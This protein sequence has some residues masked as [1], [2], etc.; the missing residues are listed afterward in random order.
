M[1]G[2]FM[3]QI[4]LLRR[5]T[6]SMIIIPH[7]VSIILCPCGWAELSPESN[8][9]DWNYKWTLIVALVG[10]LY[11][12]ISDARSHNYYH[13]IVRI[14]TLPHTLLIT[15]YPNNLLTNRFKIFEYQKYSR[16]ICDLI[17]CSDT[18]FSCFRSFYKQ[19]LKCFPTFQVTITCYSCSPSDLILL[20]TKF[21][22]CIHVN[23]PLHRVAI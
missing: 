23:L 4:Y 11:F 20:V 1:W 17:T 18:G 12:C 22:F 10:S 9:A 14:T 2:I 21:V 19:M 8:L 16:C 15:T 3:S 13:T 5:T 6:Q 7:A